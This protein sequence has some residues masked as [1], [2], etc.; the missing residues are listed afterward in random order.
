MSSKVKWLRGLLNDFNNKWGFEIEINKII[1]NKK[2]SP[3]YITSGPTT[4]II[5]LDL[6]QEKEEILEDFW[7]EVGHAL[8]CQ[9]RAHRMKEMNFFIVIPHALDSKLTTEET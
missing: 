7:H 5:K 9:Y 1:H 2:D 8:L 4:G 6:S 3:V